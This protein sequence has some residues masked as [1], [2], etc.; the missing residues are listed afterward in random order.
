MV[1][2]CAIIMGIYAI[3]SQNCAI[4]WDI[5]AI[6]HSSFTKLEEDSA[7]CRTPLNSVDFFDLFLEIS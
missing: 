2:N 5:C 3:M 4:T 7:Y 1:Q 6:N